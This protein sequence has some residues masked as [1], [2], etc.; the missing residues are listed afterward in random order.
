MPLFRA[1][2]VQLVASCN[3]GARLDGTW[4]ASISALVSGLD[5]GTVIP[6][7]TGLAGAQPLMREDLIAMMQAI[8]SLLSSANATAQRAEYLKV[9]GPANM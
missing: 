3:T 1:S 7:T 2:I 5:A 8:E 6:D 9:V 4:Q